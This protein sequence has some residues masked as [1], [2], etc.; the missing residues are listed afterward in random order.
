[1]LKKSAKQSLK[2]NWTIAIGAMLL[3][4]AISFVAN[5][6]HFIWDFWVLYSPSSD[7]AGIITW[8]LFLVCH[9]LIVPLTIGLT[10]F[11]LNIYDGTELQ[12]KQI[13]DGF[14]QFKKVIGINIMTFIFTVLWSL[15][16]IIPGIIKGISYSQASFILK[17]NPEIGVLDAISQS[18][19]MMEGYKGKYFLLGL[20]FIGWYIVIPFAFLLIVFTAVI[21]I[22]AMLILFLVFCLYLIG[23]SVYLTPYINTSL[24]A[25]YRQLTKDSFTTNNDFLKEEYDTI[26]M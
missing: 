9:I 5:M 18:K 10:W 19:H 6:P 11:Y 22:P 16:F 17:D 4:T 13:F 2:G 21:S 1:M 15:L 8:L 7:P 25:F 26:N 14:K 24:A 3:T 12:L 23:I 20:S